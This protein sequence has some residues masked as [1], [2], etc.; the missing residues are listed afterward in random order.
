MNEGDKSQAVCLTCK[1][2]VDT[3]Y[4]YATFHFPENPKKTVEDVLQGFC[5]VCG[6]AVAIPAQS[7]PKIQKE[8][9]RND[10]PVEARVPPPL[11][12]ILNM[13]SSTIRVEP[14]LTMRMLFNFFLQEWTKKGQG[15]PVGKVMKSA[16]ANRLLKGK[17]SSRVASRVD[18]EMLQT[19]ERAQARFKTNRSD[20]FK[21]VLIGAGH[22]L[23]E[24]S[25]SPKAK[26]FYK[27]ASLLGPI[28]EKSHLAATR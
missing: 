9:R 2:L 8:L 10:H 27:M 15:N 20:L 25:S 16:M 14:Q 1:N 23:V 22:D 26:R 12:D 28:E 6:T 5:D 7:T 24:R 13:V 19:L 21:A 18:V 3:T 4:R 17:A 11:E